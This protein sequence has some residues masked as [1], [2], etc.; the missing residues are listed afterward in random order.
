M[1]GSSD[2]HFQ[3]E[4]DGIRLRIRKDGILKKVIMFTHSEFKKY[5]LKLKSMAHVRLNI[6]YLPQ[7]GR[8]DFETEKG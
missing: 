5:L 2:A 1:A 7:D 4:E 6:D 8:F 3:P